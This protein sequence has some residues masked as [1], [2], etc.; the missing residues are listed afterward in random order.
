MPAIA[1]HQNQYM[2]LRLK[3]NSSIFY[4]FVLFIF[5]S[6][7]V[8][9]SCSAY[10]FNLVNN[11]LDST[12]TVQI[13]EYP[14]AIQ[15]NILKPSEV[16]RVTFAG[17][18]PDVTRMLNQYGG[19]E[20]STELAD[21]N[22]QRQKAISGQQIDKDGYLEFPYMGRIKAAG[23][24]KSE[25]QEYLKKAVE[26]YLKNPLV[27]V[28]ITSRGVTFLGEVKQPSTVSFPKE[29]AN[30]FEMM[31]QV[32]YTTEFADLTR[33]KVYRE[34]ANGSRELGAMNLNDTSFLTSPYF[35]PLPNDVVYIPSSKDK[36]T[37]ALGDLIVPFTGIFIGL[38]S[39]A[40][41][42]LN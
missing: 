3:E 37:R 4:Q 24:T 42:F 22:L 19:A 25:L 9:P 41:A 6:I 10:K 32:G 21:G 5:V 31:A 36:A 26:P 17:E 14:F 7:T 34:N 20:R 39:L 33:V 16:V 12:N 35:Y 28:E 30:L 38:L 29:R 23:I 2:A 15:E 13:K 8:L 11:Y 18:S 1:Q 27:L 40:I